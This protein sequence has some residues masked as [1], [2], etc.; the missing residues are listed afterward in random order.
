MILATFGVVCSTM[1]G[2]QGIDQP[3]RISRPGGNVPEVVRQVATSAPTGGAVEVPSNAVAGGGGVTVIGE[4]A[5]IAQETAAAAA[6]I[7]QPVGLHT[8]QLLRAFGYDRS[9]FGYTYINWPR[10]FRGQRGF[11]QQAEPEIDPRVAG[12]LRDAAP[13]ESRHTEPVPGR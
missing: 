4:E 7:N 3:V 9:N 1:V 11:Q 10:G 2:P 13:P 8:E 12:T 6:V 5:R